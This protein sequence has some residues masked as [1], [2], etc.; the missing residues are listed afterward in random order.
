MYQSCAAL[1]AWFDNWLSVPI[2]TYYTQTSHIAAQLV[3][4]LTMLG[5]W[6]KLATPK[7]LTDTGP[8]DPIPTEDPSANW[9]NAVAYTNGTGP[10]HSAS[11]PAPA[12]TALL[13]PISVSKS[14]ENKQFCSHSGKT[15]KLRLDGDPAIPTAVAALRLQLETQPS[16]QI[17]FQQILHKVGSRFDEASQAFQTASTEPGR[18]VHN[19]FSVSAMKLRITRVKLGQWAD[20][21]STKT[22][23][24]R[25][26]EARSQG[27]SRHPKQPT[28]AELDPSRDGSSM[29][30]TWM[31]DQMA[32]E[33]FYGNTP[34][35]TD[36]L[37]G[38][39]P[40]LWVNGSME[41][42]GGDVMDVLGV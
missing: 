16:L 3:F 6:A 18:K 15:D 37:Q 27:P 31:D 24:L 4:S 28:P 35:T 34:W 10:L 21:I 22:A 29:L 42:A 41:W 19:I 5:R 40:A 11:T 17:D 8:P 38:V 23:A 7:T 13:S 2:S 39:D 20:L 1:T 25:V 26:D 9:P 30:G 32:I 33:N 12:N 36:L 14:S